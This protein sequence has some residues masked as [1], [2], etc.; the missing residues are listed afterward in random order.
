MPYDRRSIG[1]IDTI[2]IAAGG[3]GGADIITDFD[4]AAG[5]RLNLTD[6][7][8]GAVD[9]F[10]L[11]LAA[12]TVAADSA[13]FV[14]GA[15]AAGTGTFTINNTGTDTLVI[16]NDAAITAGNLTIANLG[17]AANSSVTVLQNINA[18]LDAGW[19]V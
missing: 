6:I 9:L 2:I 10:G 4:G 11:T 15:Y 12:G 1:C 7:G 17:L 8:G 13:A 19:L 14:R 16:R 18:N 5:D 3:V